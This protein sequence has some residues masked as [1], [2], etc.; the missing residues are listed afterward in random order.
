MQILGT[1]SYMKF[2][3]IC[4]TFPCFNVV[5]SAHTFFLPHITVC[6]VPLFPR[7]FCPPLAKPCNRHPQLYKLRWLR[8]STW[9][10]E[11]QRHSVCLCMSPSRLPAA[12][13]RYQEKQGL[14]LSVIRL[15]HIFSH[16]F[17][18]LAWTNDLL[19]NRT[20]L[21]VFTA[22]S[23]NSSGATRGA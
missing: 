10:F 22:T 12:V 23:I 20:H 18:V 3:T 17:S 14:F 1:I 16:F 13:R 8:K 5:F 9:W 2:I 19:D 15:L 6:I 4:A 21:T 7:D 11:I